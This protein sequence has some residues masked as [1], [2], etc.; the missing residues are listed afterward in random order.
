MCFKMI[1]TMLNSEWKV[2]RKYKIKFGDVKR[3]KC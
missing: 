1:I 3:N 2:N